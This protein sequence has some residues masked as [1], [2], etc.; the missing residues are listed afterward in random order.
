[1]AEGEEQ[2]PIS[3]EA[4]IELGFEILEKAAKEK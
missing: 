3:W 1:L 4:L 2:N